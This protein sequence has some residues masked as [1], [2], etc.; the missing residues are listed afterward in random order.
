MSIILNV[1][2]TRE[3]TF[4]VFMKKLMKLFYWGE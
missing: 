2:G 1:D 4:T 3:G